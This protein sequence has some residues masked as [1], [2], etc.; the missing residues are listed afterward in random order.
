[1][2]HNVRQS[3]LPHLPQALNYLV[4][5]IDPIN[6]QTAK[7]TFHF[8]LHSP[9]FCYVPLGVIVENESNQRVAGNYF[10]VRNGLLICLKEK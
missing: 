5:Y 7:S 4:I 6:G 3:H 1:M 10:I 8:V 9:S 2:K